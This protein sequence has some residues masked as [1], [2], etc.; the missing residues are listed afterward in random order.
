MKSRFIKSCG[1]ALAG[2]FLA[3]PALAADA[4]RVSTNHRIARFFDERL[5]EPPLF[6][7]DPERRS[8]VEEAERWANDTLQ[9]VARRIVLPAMARDRR[10]SAARPETAG[11][12]TSSTGER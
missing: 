7:A 4:H 8:A 12:D 9:M 1:L 6:P 5:P 3:M 11:W 10:G 2:A